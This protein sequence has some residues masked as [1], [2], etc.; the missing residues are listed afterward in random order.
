MKVNIGKFPK[1]AGGQTIRVEI[2]RH[3]TYSCDHTLAYI[4]YPLLLQLRETKHGVPGEF[5]EVGGADYDLQDSFDFY[6]ETHGESFDKSCDKWDEILNKMIWSFEQL[7]N[8]EY[9]SQYHHG[10]ANYD[11]VKTEDK[12]YNPLTGKMETMHRM[13][14]RNPDEHWYDHVGH[15]VHEDRIQ[16]GLDLF[17][18]YFRNL[19]D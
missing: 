12:H 17:G 6:K 9:D 8:D 11:W 3:D 5:A 19:W 1:G 18:K 16:E 4:I 13:V 14:D 10:E 7:I 2:N 15:R